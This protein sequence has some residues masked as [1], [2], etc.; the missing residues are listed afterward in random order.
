MLTENDLAVIQQK[1]SIYIEKVLGVS[2]MEEYQYMICDE[3]AA[4]SRVAIAACHA[5]GKTWLMARIAM[6]FLSCHPNSKVITT[7]PTAR[8]VE[9]LLWGEIG[10]A[11]KSAKMQLGGS[12]TNKQWKLGPDWYAVGFSPKK[13]AGG[14]DSNEQKGSTFQGWHADYILIIFDEAV[15]VPPDVWTQ[16][17]GLLTSGKIVKFV[18]I[19]NPTTKNCN[20][21]DCFSSEAW[22]KIHLSCFNSP[23]L[24]VNGIRDINDMLKEEKILRELGED[25]RLIRMEGYKKIKTHLL[26]CQW[27]FE[28]LLEWGIEHPLFQSKVLGKFPDIDDSVMIQLGDVEAAQNRTHDYSER[29]RRYIGVDVAR[30]GEDKTVFTELFGTVHTRTKAL[31]KRDT[32]EVV[33]NL[34]KFCID[35]DNGLET[36]VLIDGTGIGSGVIDGMKEAQKTK[37]ANGKLLLPKHFKVM[38]IHFAMAVSQIQHGEKPNEKELQDQATYANLKAFMFDKLGIDL[39][40]TLR[41]RKDAVYISELPTIKYKFNGQ[42]RMLVESKEDYKKRT[43]KNSP[44]YSDSLALANLGRY[45]K[46]SIDYLRKLTG[47]K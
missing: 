13:E 38:E 36:F 18:C 47:G 14:D 7:A 15:G 40:H 3:V 32:T 45:L 33:G 26:S 4:R 29:D 41:I 34:I 10:V 39:K 17:E 6:W 19:A 31:A 9:M 11:F 22:R 42:G 28:K 1:P 20:F 21:Y 27:V 43:G 12:L 46:P 30:F 35:E 37:D 2:S 25:E 16:V 5:V 23:N 44:D 8:Q 24:A